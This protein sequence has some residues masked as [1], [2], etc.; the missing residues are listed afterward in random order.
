MK[1]LKSRALALSSAVAVG[2]LSAP[3]VHAAGLA[4]LTDAVDFAEVGTAVM[5]IAVALAGIF[6]L[7]KGAA[8]VLRAIRGL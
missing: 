2:L 1:W 7:W 3:V 5:A 8:L 4:D 6:V